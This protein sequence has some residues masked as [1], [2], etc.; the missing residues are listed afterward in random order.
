MKYFFIFLFVSQ[1]CI[2]LNAQSI[3]SSN[4]QIKAA[5][6]KVKIL[7][8][9]QKP[10]PCGVINYISVYKAVVI[11]KQLLKGNDTIILYVQ[12]RESYD[13]KQSFSQKY[14]VSAINGEYT[15]KDGTIVNLSNTNLDF[16]EK[17][18]KYILLSLTP[19][20]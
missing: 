5:N 9:A 13:K 19:E 20:F 12:C 6:F 2:C 10:S 16:I 3:T 8:F 17:R 15:S 1:T 18:R 4:K 11:G 14:K 7:N